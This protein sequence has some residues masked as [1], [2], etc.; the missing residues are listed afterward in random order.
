[1]TPTLYLNNIAMPLT[2]GEGIKLTKAINDFGSIQESKSAFSSSIAI[3]RTS[4]I[5][6]FFGLPT[7]LNASSSIYDRFDAKIEVGG[8]DLIGLNAFAFV[9]SVDEWNVKVKVYSA[10]ADLFT[11]IKGKKLEEIDLSI[12]DH[13]YNANNVNNYRTAEFMDIASVVYPD[14]NYGKQYDTGGTSARP[15]TYWRPAVYFYWIVKKII[16]GAGFTFDEASEIL[17]DSRFQQ[18]AICQTG[19]FSRTPNG[20]KFD[21]DFEIDSITTSLY[22]ATQAAILIPYYGINSKDVWIDKDSVSGGFYPKV[23]GVH[24]KWTLSMTASSSVSNTLT[25]VLFT[26]DPFVS[27]PYFTIGTFPINSGTTDIY[28]EWESVLQY[29]DT[30]TPDKSAIW[31]I[32]A[33]NNAATFTDVKIIFKGYDVTNPA[34]LEVNENQGYNVVEVAGLLPKMTQDEFLK[35]V[36]QMFYAVPIID[37]TNKSVKLNFA[38][39]IPV[40]EY[41]VLNFDF[42]Q[43]PEKVPMFGNWAQRNRFT[44]QYDESDEITKL[45]PTYAEGYLYCD[46]QGIDYE[47]VFTELP[48]GASAEYVTFGGTRKLMF[49]PVDSKKDPKQRICFVTLDFSNTQQP[50]AISGMST[51]FYWSYAQFEPLAWWTLL[52]VYYQNWKNSIRRPVAMKMKAKLNALQFRSFDFEK[53]VY[54]ERYQS[55]F[56]VNKISEY[57]ASDE[58]LTE[59]ELILIR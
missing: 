11:L 44:Y 18:A 46:Y 41:Q 54:I 36:L 6:S 45:N 15:F 58:Q 21:F 14:I 26:I 31:A 1:M 10:A 37:E 5:E 33:T 25:L 17:T 55:L 40:N 19:A 2:E 13:T 23:K 16:E 29:G 48:Y 56:Y 30:S 32:L 43:E 24:G 59:V 39:S 28:V 22:L 4:F 9:E 35:S 42:T 50:I 20:K 38:N 7:D 52:S 53:P 12:G 47:K 51:P 34:D 49:I 57:D 3:K 27:I 8:T